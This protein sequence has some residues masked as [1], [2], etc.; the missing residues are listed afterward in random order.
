MTPMN[1]FIFGSTGDLVRR[2][3]MPA[4]VSL[5][6]R[7][8]S[9]IA[10][11]RK[12][13]T[14]L[15]YE[16]FVCDDCFKDF[17][18]APRY[19]KI[20]F[21]K[22]IVCEQCDRFLD[23]N[24]ENFFY[25]ALPPA[26][27]SSVFDYVG[28]LKRAGYKVN[29]LVEKP[30]G[31]DLQ[32]ALDLREQAQKL[33]LLEELYVSDHYL[34]KDA[35]INLSP[36]PFKNLKMVSLESVGLEKRAAYFDEVG[37]IKDMLQS[38]FLNT[39]FRAVNDPVAEFE[40]FT[41]S[42]FVLGQYEGYKEELLKSSATETYFDIAIETAGHSYEFISGKA[43]DKKMGFLDLDGN[44]QMLYGKDEDYG[45]LF[46]DFFA[47]KKSGFASVDNSILAWRILDKLAVSRPNLIY[48]KPRLSAE[49][50]LHGPAELTSLK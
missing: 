8:L 41:V 37:L 24:A 31:S 21:E 5:R 9:I 49:S 4:L 14:D 23:K 50:V 34:F 40:N 10:L 38:H 18:V 13:F 45:R 46:S 17:D 35:I 48:Y 16:Q 2:K 29:I 19:H 3:I 12:E 1:L 39:A 20:D 6:L 30:F 32:N 28:G 15:T 43:F 7:G 42:R 25:S 47:K 22:Q 26:Q 27:M 36:I 11:G 33:N 44:R